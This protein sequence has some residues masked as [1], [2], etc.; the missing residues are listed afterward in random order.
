MDNTTDMVS[1]I[2][3]GLNSSMAM[4]DRE[5]SYSYEPCPVEGCPQPPD[6]NNQPVEEKYEHKK[7]NFFIILFLSY[8]SQRRWSDPTSWPSGQLPVEGEDVTILSTWRML[9]DISP[10]P[11]GLVLIDGELQFEDARDYN[12]TANIV[13]KI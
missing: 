1:Y 13:R 2:I 3:S 4:L 7:N 6:P 8:Y 9:L 10:P 5:W 11:L 12:F